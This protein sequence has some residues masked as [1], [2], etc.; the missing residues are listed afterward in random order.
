MRTENMT[1]SELIRYADLPAKVVTEL[2][3][4]QTL[5]NEGSS[6]VMEY[7]RRIELLEEQIYFAVRTIDNFEAILKLG[8]TPST[9]IK[10]LRAELG[11][12]SL[13]R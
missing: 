12:C 1:L 7:Q 8:D 6:E 4:L 3:R 10:L 5:D 11:A 13:E 2:E 9:K